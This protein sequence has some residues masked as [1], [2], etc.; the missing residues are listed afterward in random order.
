M[1]ELLAVVGGEMNRYT[2]SSLEG[3]EGRE[4][5]TGFAEMGI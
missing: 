1:S 3:F 4:K 2:Y 5:E